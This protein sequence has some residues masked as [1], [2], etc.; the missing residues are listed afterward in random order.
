MQKRR[1]NAAYRE[2]ENKKAKISAGG[3]VPE[4]TVE[5]T[6][7]N[8]DK[9]EKRRASKRA[10]MQKQRVTKAYRE[11]ERRSKHNA[12]NFRSECVEKTK[13]LMEVSVTDMEK[14]CLKPIMMLVLTHVW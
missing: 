13:K 4:K 7:D 6:P 5:H 11:R 3:N 14:Q 1:A 9:V 8:R 10:Y 12:K 2:T